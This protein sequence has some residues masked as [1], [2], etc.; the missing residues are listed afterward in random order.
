MISSPGLSDVLSSNW[1][2]LRTASRKWKKSQLDT[3]LVTYP[4]RLSNVFTEVP[5]VKT[6]FLNKMLETFA[7]DP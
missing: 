5:F 1:K 4:A 7:Q 2:E 3:D 6:A